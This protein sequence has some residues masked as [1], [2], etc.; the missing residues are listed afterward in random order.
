MMLSPAFEPRTGASCCCRLKL[1]CPVRKLRWPI[2]AGS[3]GILCMLLFDGEGTRPKMLKQPPRAEITA[4]GRTPK[5]EI[6]IVSVGVLKEL[7]FRR[8]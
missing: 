1:K 3:I 5:R 7:S 2:F 4:P 8:I 6:S